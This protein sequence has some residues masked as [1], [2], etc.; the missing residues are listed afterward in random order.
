MQIR[1][2]V[3]LYSIKKGSTLL[4]KDL[5]VCVVICR[6]LAFILVCKYISAAISNILI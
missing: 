6:L 1:L 4:R 2:A 5:L 3:V